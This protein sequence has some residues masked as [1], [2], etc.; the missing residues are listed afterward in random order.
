MTPEYRI[1]KEK[2]IREYLKSY[3]TSKIKYMQVENTFNDLGV[4]IHV[5]NIKTDKEAWWIVDGETAPMNLYPQDAFYFSADEAYSFHMGIMQ[6]LNARHQKEFKHIIDEI[7]LDIERIKS[8]KQRLNRVSQELNNSFNSEDIQS[9]GLACRESLIELGNELSL[10]N[11]T[12]IEQSKLKASDFKGIAN[13]IIDLYIP[14]KSNS[15]LRQ[16]AKRLAEMAWSYASEIVHSQ[17]RNIPDAKICILFT[18]SVVTIFENLF[19]KYLGFD[20]EPKCN[21]CKSRDHD[22]LNTEVETELIFH[23][24]ECGHEELIET[25][26]VDEIGK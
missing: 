12:I 22:I 4:E 23:C 10:R 13:A 3:D 6:R 15:S 19:L 21:K 7:P 8:I 14:G 24:N 9:I 16:H 5:W 26:L 25:Q 20:N 18:C 17:N 2:Q 11:P 1:E